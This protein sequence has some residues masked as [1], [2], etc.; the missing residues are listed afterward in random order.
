M[1]VAEQAA[2]QSVVSP[3]KHVIITKNRFIVQSLCHTEYALLYHRKRGR[4]QSNGL[5]FINELSQ[6][7]AKALPLQERIPCLQYLPRPCAEEK[8]A[9]VTSILLA[10]KHTILVSSRLI[11]FTEIA[12]SR[13]IKNFFSQFTLLMQSLSSLTTA[14]E[15]GDHHA[16]EL[17]T[18]TF[19]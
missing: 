6:L 11:D 3:F 13:T 17:R 15:N 5:Q 16:R 8:G 18:T 4:N 12:Q 19:K 7:L 14:Q 10:C 9:I 1:T 2:I